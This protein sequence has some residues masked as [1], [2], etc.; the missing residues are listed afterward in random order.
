[1]HPQKD[2]IERKLVARGKRHVDLC[3]GEKN[4]SIARGEGCHRTYTG[5]FWVL[6]EVSKRHYNYE[7]D[8][9]NINF[10]AKPNKQV[11]HIFR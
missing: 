7:P 9:G 11:R 3:F 5:P 10:H 6:P 1:M 4:D 2:D 8:A